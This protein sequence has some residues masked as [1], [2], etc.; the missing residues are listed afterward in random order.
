LHSVRL[1]LLIR[2][3]YFVPEFRTLLNTLVYKSVGNAMFEQQIE[4]TISVI[5]RNT[6]GEASSI[7]LKAILSSDISPSIKNYFDLDVKQWMREEHDRLL[8]SPH[9]DYSD[10]TIRAMFDDIKHQ[11]K[12]MIRFTR[13]EFDII[14]DQAVKL[15][16]NYICR[17]QWTLSKFVFGEK[18]LVSSDSISEALEYFVD[19]DYYSVIIAQYLSSKRYSTMHRDRFEELVTIIDNEV[20]KGFDSRKMAQIAVP[21][22]ALF[23]RG[24]DTDTALIPI[25]ALSV[26]YDDKNVSPIVERLDAEKE[27]MPMLS[28]HDLTVLISE[29][30]FSTSVDIS[31]LV[32][33]HLNPDRKDTPQATL[34]PESY[35]GAMPVAVEEEPAAP[36]FEEEPAM[37]TFEQDSTLPTFEEESD[38]PTFEEEPQEIELTIEPEEDLPIAEVPEIEPV[39]EPEVEIPVEETNEAFPSFDTPVEDNTTSTEP[40]EEESFEIPDL[41]FESE[42]V[43]TD[44][45]TIEQSEML[46][47]EDDAL[48]DFPE[49]KL[50]EDEEGESSLDGTGGEAL[51]G[52]EHETPEFDEFLPAEEPTNDAEIPSIEQSFTNET[53]ISPDDDAIEIR[54]ESFPGTIEDDSV[55]MDFSIDGTEQEGE[56][57]EDLEAFFKDLGKQSEESAD[58]SLSF[59]Q[60]D[61]SSEELKGIEE[62]FLPE[63]SINE[64]S[65]DGS[66][67]EAATDEALPFA[68]DGDAEASEEFSFSADYGDKEFTPPE[69]DVAFEDSNPM[70]EEQKNEYQTEDE[71]HFKEFDF[72]PPEDAMTLPELDLSLDDADSDLRAN[73]D[74]AVGLEQSS[75][76][77]SDEL[78][79]LMRDF[80]R[81]NSAEE[82][83]GINPMDSF[84]DL[85]TTIP[86]KDKKLYIKTLF[87]KNEQDFERALDDLNKKR[88]WRDA[89]EYIDELFLQHDV[90]MY[91]KTAIKFTD[92]VYKRYMS[93]S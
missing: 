65:I 82:D 55:N 83:D 89:S 6:I 61:G 77:S 53:A 27:S 63:Q 52:G 81:D 3:A 60:P 48:P 79:D 32:N 15:Q 59:L 57:D 24:A 67:T 69:S 18:E 68:I 5:T 36:V 8:S 72:E 91:S 58:E 56:S 86:A 84:G 1:H 71:T 90:D 44:E 51:S 47:E 88:S 4:E 20:L 49:F 33:Q 80:T 46:D 78:T 75:S 43:E 38:T 29:V 54:E 41:T 14:L 22:Y 11:S 74:S 62:T 13:E 66:V 7:T 16:F 28:M 26:F 17:P 9:F 40:V 85:K 25:E 19:Y 30:D 10:E 35:E 39:L 31:N 87:N 2:C 70:N 92:E 45:G 50:A 12:P 76:G 34:S 37:P 64:L 42:P 23:S 21:L 73:I 93:K